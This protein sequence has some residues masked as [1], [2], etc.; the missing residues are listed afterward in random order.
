MHRLRAVHQK[1]E[2][3]VE[4]EPIETNA[5]LRSLSVWRCAGART[6]F[7]WLRRASL[8]NQ[9]HPEGIRRQ[10]EVGSTL[11]VGHGASAEG[12][13]DAASRQRDSSFELSVVDLRD[14]GRGESGSERQIPRERRRDPR[15]PP[16]TRQRRFERVESGFLEPD[17]LEVAALVA[18]VKTSERG[19]VR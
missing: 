7:R 8:R 6:V 11:R 15:S 16:L 19:I 3:A 17:C 18:F 1:A 13:G 12:D 14:T 2:V 9:H 5:H 10:L 4:L